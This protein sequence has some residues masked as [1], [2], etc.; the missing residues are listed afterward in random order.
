MRMIRVPFLDGKAQAGRA[1]I[2]DDADFH[3]MR[4]RWMPAPL[5]DRPPDRY[6]AIYV[7]GDSLLDAR[8]HPG[9]WVM[10]RMQD[11]AEDGQLVVVAHG[12]GVCVKYWHPID[13]ETVELRSA[14]PRFKPQTWGIEQLRIRGVVV[15]AGQDFEKEGD[16]EDEA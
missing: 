1:S 13:D 4:I 7:D 2:P 16:R 9:D 12:H 14:N 5:S 15:M 3:I 6:M 8:I 10:F 11:F